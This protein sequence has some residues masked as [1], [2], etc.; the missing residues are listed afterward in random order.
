MEFESFLSALAQEK[1][2][3]AAL[4]SSVVTEKKESERNKR[5]RVECFY[6]FNIVAA[7]SAGFCK[8]INLSL[9]S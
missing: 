9:Y 3:S 5:M 6:I 8:V 4:K 2:N 1:K 7:K